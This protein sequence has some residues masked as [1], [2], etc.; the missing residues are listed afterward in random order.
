MKCPSCKTTSHSIAES[1]SHW[2]QDETPDCNVIDQR[3]EQA[4]RLGF[5]INDSQRNSQPDVEVAVA[6]PEQV[7]AQT[8][9][10]TE[11]AVVSMQTISHSLWE[12]RMAVSQDNCVQTPDVPVY[13]S[14]GFSIFSDGK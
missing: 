9:M 12:E 10:A 3:R 13:N 11:G 14:A 5:P 7:D 8:E 6:Q 2:C 1:T 4:E